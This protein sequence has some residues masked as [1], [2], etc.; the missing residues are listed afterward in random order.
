MPNP[1][2]ETDAGLGVDMEFNISVRVG[3]APQA[4]L[5]SLPVRSY[6]IYILSINLYR[7]YRVGLV[8]VG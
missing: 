2:F 8:L 7:H 1:A 4:D 5:K 6:L 3:F